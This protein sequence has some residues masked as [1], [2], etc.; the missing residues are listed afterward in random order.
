MK[1]S[2]IYATLLAALSLAGCSTS[3]QST[4]ASVPSDTPQQHFSSGINTKSNGNDTGNCFWGNLFN[5][6]C[7]ESST[8]NIC[9]S[10]LSAQLALSMTAAG[11]TGE[12]QQEMYS[13]MNL[14]G[15][16]N[17]AAKECLE[18]FSKIN[19][20]CEVSIANSIWI[21]EKLDVKKN[22]IDT[23]KEYFNA[24]VTTAPFNKKT[25]QA[26]N[27][28]CSDNTKGK[29]TSILNDIKKSDRMYLIN[30]LYFKGGWL[31]EFNASMTEEKPFTK[32]NGKSINVPMMC[33]EIKTQYYEDNLVQIATKHFKGGYRMLLV[34]PAEGVTVE[35]A[36]THLASNYENTV[37]SMSNYDVTISM[38]K[39]QSEFSTSLK[40]TL[41]NLGMERAFSSNAQFG[42]ISD[43]PLNIDNVLQKTFI[44]VD[45]KGAEAAAATAV[46]MLTGSLPRPLEKKELNLNRTFYYIIDD[47]TPR[48]IL[49]IGKV[50]N[51]LE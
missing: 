32:E 7:A 46:M 13:A 47:Y 44:K 30:A 36:V 17:V 1:K 37:G 39:F 15:D 22:F 4:P 25:L 49:F 19:Y 5:A 42:G 6:V 14:T 38:P 28:W 43:T 29:I 41:E 45:E 27:S 31:K 16:V 21:N 23:N 8:E 20:D 40:N 10:P 34:L 48:N 33:Q 18:K 2:R 9:I 51:P 11:A 12:T 50:G 26:I 24:L 3:R 35:E